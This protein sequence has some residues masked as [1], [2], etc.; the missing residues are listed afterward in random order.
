MTTT[1]GTHL[2][3]W[4]FKLLADALAGRELRFVNVKLG[5][6]VR[7]GE[8]VYPTREEA[9]EF[10]DLINAR[11]FL[12]E[13]EAPFVSI[14]RIGGG[15]VSVSFMIRN[16]NIEQG[17]YNRE[18]GLFAVDSDTGEEHL[19]CY[20]NVGDLCEWVPDSTSKR[21]A[22]VRMSIVTVIQEAANV[23]AIID[24]GLAYVT[25]AEFKAH[26]DAVRPHP[27]A[28]CL[29]DEV[30][31][32]KYFWAQDDD[33]NLHPISTYNARR[34]ILGSDAADIPKIDRRLTQ[35]EINVANL[36]MQ[37]NSEREL[38]LEPNLML[39]EDFADTAHVDTYEC[40]VTAQAAG[41]AEICVDNDAD[42]LC[43]HWYT[44]TDGINQEYLQV[45]SIAK[46]P[47][48]VIVIFEQILNKTYNLACTYLMRSTARIIDG[49]ATGA[50]DLRGK[51]YTFPDVWQ[52]TGANQAATQVLNTSQGNVDNFV[53]SGDYA[54]TSNAEFTLAPM[55]PNK[56]DND[57]HR[58]AMAVTVNSA[59]GDFGILT[60]GL[61]GPGNEYYASLKKITATKPNSTLVGNKNENTFEIVGGENNVI[62][63]GLNRDY[64]VFYGGGGI[65]TDF[66]INSLNDKTGKMYA[67]VT[68]QKA[69]DSYYAYDRT[70]P[71]TYAEGN[72]ILKVNGVVTKIVFSGYG[73]DT[74]KKNQTFNATV[75][76]R[77]AEGNTHTVELQNIVKGMSAPNY[78]SDSDAAKLLNI[79][80]NRT[81]EL[82]QLKGTTLTSLF[83]NS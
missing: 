2:T 44:I 62:T 36:Y 21:L 29:G 48:A 78:K 22:D 52:G 11:E 7:D 72:D 56:F 47:E 4:G 5:D 69:T 45:R 6:S 34:L 58:S 1:D 37:L 3:R 61:N 65:I 70:K 79:W 75:H 26:V 80:D 10:D 73:D 57:A 63:G 28:P 53:L 14:D 77:D 42:I 55:V 71:T 35:A 41:I 12:P 33:I 66:G 81:G 23:T 49:C 16:A 83:R 13:G 51:T 17:F 9:Y 74:S 31:T 39:V 8:I 32:T 20:C 46:N 38:G 40:R 67:K 64:Y 15:M 60:N 82:A 76:Y 18:M 27:N 54:F 19:Y 25:Q 24:G 43:G 50:G 68:T 30:T 59:Y